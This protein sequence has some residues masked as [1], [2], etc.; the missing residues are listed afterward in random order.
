MEPSDIVAKVLVEHPRLQRPVESYLRKGK[1]RPATAPSPP[2][3]PSGYPPPTWPLKEGG[4]ASSCQRL[5]SSFDKTKKIAFFGGQKNI[6]KMFR[7]LK[8]KSDSFEFFKIFSDFWTFKFFF[9]IF[10]FLFVFLM[11]FVCLFYCFFFI[12]LIF[13]IFEI[14]GNFRFFGIFLV[15]FFFKSYYGYY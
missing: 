15:R 5:I 13:W 8:K 7:F 9:Y 11:Y 6:F 10:V 14:F 2:P 4:R 1:C 12:S 3:S